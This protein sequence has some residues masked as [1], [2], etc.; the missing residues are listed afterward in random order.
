MCDNRSGGGQNQQWAIERDFVCRRRYYWYSVP[1]HNAH[2]TNIPNTMSSKPKST[3]VRCRELKEKDT[4]LVNEKEREG[5]E[6]ER[7]IQIF[8]L[9]SPPLSRVVVPPH[10]QI[11]KFQV[12]VIKE[13]QEEQTSLV[14]TTD[15]RRPIDSFSQF[16]ST[17][18]KNHKLAN[19]TNK[20]QAFLP[21]ILSSHLSIYAPCPTME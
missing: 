7:D 19:N 20:Q 3:Y 12:M 15:D 4:Q 14:P 5:G 8:L 21:C 18:I 11:L 2:A 17:Q 13:G 10:G 16:L 9:F 1:V 6:R